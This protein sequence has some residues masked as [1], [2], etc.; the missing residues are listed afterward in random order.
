MTTA[1]TRTDPLEV[2]C[3]KADKAIALARTGE[4]QRGMLAIVEGRARLR[5]TGLDNCPSS[6]EARRRLRAAEAVIDGL[7]VDDSYAICDRTGRNW[8]P[9]TDTDVIDGGEVFVPEHTPERYAPEH[10]GEPYD[11][12]PLGTLPVN[13]HA[14]DHHGDVCVEG[15]HGTLWFPFLDCYMPA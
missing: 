7:D 12:G 1:Q 3:A 4:R 10:P 15:L 14:P 9:V 5:R 6:H 2:A 8:R 11:V 13:G